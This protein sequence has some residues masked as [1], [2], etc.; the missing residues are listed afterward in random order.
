MS[1]SVA[2]YRNIYTEDRFRQTYGTE[3]KQSGKSRLRE[4]LSKPCRCSRDS[5]LHLLK[6]RVPIFSWLPKYRLRKWILGDTV[7]GLTVGILHIPQGKTVCFPLHFTLHK[8]SHSHPLRRGCGSLQTH[9]ADT[10]TADTSVYMH[11]RVSSVVVSE[12]FQLIKLSF[13]IDIQIYV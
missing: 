7:A 3:A 13:F 4:T 2:V 11:W 5:C 8:K 12:L 10:N 9:T 6:E 1:A